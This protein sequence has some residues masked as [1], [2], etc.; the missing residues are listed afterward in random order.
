[1]SDAPSSPAT[2]ST[3]APFNVDRSTVTP[4]IDIQ[5]VSHFYGEGEGRKQV[6]FENNLTIY[7]GEIVIMTG[8]SGSGK[9]T[10]LTLIGALRS[11]QQGSLKVLGREMQGLSSAEQVK[12]R[13]N[14]GFIF[15]AHNLFESLTAYQNVR[16]PT[17]LH[18]YTPQQR[19]DLPVKMLTDLGL[20]ARLQYKPANLSGGQR[21][22]VAIGRALVNSPKLVLADE[23]T[24]ALD[25]DTGRQV[26]NLL[27]HLA[28]SQGAAIMIVTHDNRILDVA[29]RIVNM[30]DGYIV[31]N[32]EVAEN[33]A[34]SKFLSKCSVFEGAAPQ[35]LS[36]VAAKMKREKH[37]PGSVIIRQ[38]DIGDKFYVV[39]NGRAEVSRV[40][41]GNKTDTLVT[42]GP[43]AF[44][45]ELALLRDEPR[46]AT[47]TAVEPVEVLTLSKDIFLQVRQN[48]GTFEEQL[49][50]ATFR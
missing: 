29:D 11:L 7:P 47:V 28:K 30:V 23:P 10:L 8:P 22:R 35:L 36:D 49:R 9:T 14:I 13:R 4:A 39:R 6:L 15:Q 26:V 5:G 18:D 37:A 21:Q 3:A 27:Q 48:I 50:K 31:S 45:G 41:D 34:I 25:K 44:F 24:A 42:L 2:R 16:L 38:G 43:G 1:M 33:I 17:E 40:R 12:V 20:A 19:H 32:I 46:A